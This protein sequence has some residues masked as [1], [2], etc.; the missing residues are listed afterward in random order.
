MKREFY[1]YYTIRV[2]IKVNGYE[3]FVAFVYADEMRPRAYGNGMT[4]FNF[5]MGGQLVA[6]LDADQM[7]MTEKRFQNDKW[8]GY[9]HFDYDYVQDMD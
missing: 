6:S 2:L 8:A 4:W 7:R 3:R 1:E 9:A 5:F